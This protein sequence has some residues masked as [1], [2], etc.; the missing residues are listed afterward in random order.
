[1]NWVDIAI[2]VIIGLSV[3]ISLVRGFVREAMSL[4]VWVA[5][6]FVASAFYS[7][8]AVLF[9]SLDDPLIRNAVAIVLLFVV[10]L[11][12]GSLLTYII[13]QL[14]D[15]T[16]LTGF[17]RL[18]GMIFGALRGVLVVAAL[19]FAVDSFTTLS[20]STWWKSS[21]LIPEFGVVVQWFFEYLQ[22]SSSFLP[23][24]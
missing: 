10:T 4:V 9:T 16:G 2:L 6:F 7:K 15:K 11:L 5:A 21:K 20:D 17:D 18:L 14:V 19:L 22:A 12:L 24:G 8:L 1:M 23:K 3:L 13:G